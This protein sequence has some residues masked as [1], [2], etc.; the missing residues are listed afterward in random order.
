MR[1]AAPLVADASALDNTLVASSVPTPAPTIALEFDGAADV[2]DVTS[3]PE[4]AAPSTSRSVA[5]L[6]WTVQ[7]A[8][9]G[10][11]QPEVQILRT[12]QPDGRLGT[13]RLGVGSLAGI[14]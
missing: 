6:V 1:D 12:L 2:V 14:A 13:W 3:A 7:D 8:D 9:T 4:S 5:V 11:A 10:T